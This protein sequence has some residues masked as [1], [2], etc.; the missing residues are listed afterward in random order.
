MENEK[1]TQIEPCMHLVCSECLQQWQNK[2]Q[3]HSPTCPFCRCDIKGFEKIKISKAKKQSKK[4]EVGSEIDKIELTQPNPEEESEEGKDSTVRVVEQTEPVGA[5]NFAF[6]SEPLPEPPVRN[7]P[8]VPRRTTSR[9]VFPLL[10][11]ILLIGNLI[12]NFYQ[13]SIRSILTTADSA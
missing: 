2:D 4:E 1:D 12:G 9:T 8:S 6:E 7:Q 13:R 10:Q 5:V 11:S 3:S